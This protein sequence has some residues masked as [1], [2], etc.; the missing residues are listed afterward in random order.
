MGA[1]KTLNPPLVSNYVSIYSS[2][3]VLHFCLSQQRHLGMQTVDLERI[4]HRWEETNLWDLEVTQRTGEEEE[5]W[6]EEKAGEH[7]GEVEV[8]KHHT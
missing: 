4:Q 1:T 2:I 3:C 6:K 8:E 5:P 7:G